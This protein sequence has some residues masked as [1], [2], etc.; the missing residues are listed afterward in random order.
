MKRETQYQKKGKR[1]LH[2]TAE[3]I[4]YSKESNDQQELKRIHFPMS[5]R[6]DDE[7]LVAPSPFRAE[8]TTGVRVSWTKASD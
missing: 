7:L 4:G 1:K 2:I 6:C 5:N 3:K 8:G